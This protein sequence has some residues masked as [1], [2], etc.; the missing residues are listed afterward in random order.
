MMC[1]YAVYII[2]SYYLEKKKEKICFATSILLIQFT[3]TQIQF[4]FIAINRLFCT[5]GRNCS[6]E[7][8][9]TT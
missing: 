5:G 4:I 3:R 8:G 2:N 9:H 6:G 7:V 1:V